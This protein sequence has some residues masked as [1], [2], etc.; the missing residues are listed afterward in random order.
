MRKYKSFYELPLNLSVKDLKEILSISLTVVY[1]LAKSGQVRSIRMRRLYLSQ[2]LL[3]WS[4]LKRC[5]AG[6]HLLQGQHLRE[7]KQ[8]TDL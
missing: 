1:C 7:Y 5:V 3:L 4:I 6:K 8:E 2:M